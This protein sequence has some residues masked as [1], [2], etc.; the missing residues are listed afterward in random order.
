MRQ[1]FTKAIPDTNAVWERH[2]QNHHNQTPPT[3]PPPNA[4]CAMVQEATDQTGGQICCGTAGVYNLTRDECCQRCIADPR[5][6][7]WV[8]TYPVSNNNNNNNDNNDNNSNNTFENQKSNNISQ[9]WTISGARGSRYRV[10]R[11]VGYIPGRQLS[12]AGDENA[13]LAGFPAFVNGGRS[14]A[15]AVELNTVS[16]GGCQLQ[17]TQIRRWSETNP[18]TASATVSTPL[19]LYSVTGRSLI[20]SPKK[21]FFVGTHS[22]ST[23]PGL[24]E[25]GLKASLLSVPLPDPN[26]GGGSSSNFIHET[27]ITVGHGANDTLVAFGDEL[28]RVRGKERIDGY[29]DFMLAHLGHW[30]D[31]GSFLYHNPAPWPNYQEAL[32]AVKADAEA[33]NIPYRYS[34]VSFF[35]FIFS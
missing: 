27:L 24:W 10:D 35:G 25:A 2:Q 32:L 19:L 18:D 13:V 23:N 1:V 26:G 15:A 33:R 31:A 17:G 12:H 9:C 11:Q 14:G 8:M 21:N 34:Q 3:P 22:S 28:L 29:Q 20:I 5:C 6:N 7:A 16:F 4:V 30:N